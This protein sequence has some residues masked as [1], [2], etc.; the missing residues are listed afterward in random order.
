MKNSESL[1]NQFVEF[2]REKEKI[3]ERKKELEKE[4]KKLD[5]EAAKI[6]VKSDKLGQAIE[7]LESIGM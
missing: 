2:A 4:K 7:L 1:K 6:N 5:E 3:E